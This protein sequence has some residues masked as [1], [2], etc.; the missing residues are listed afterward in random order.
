MSAGDRW[1]AGVDSGAGV[2]RFLAALAEVLEGL[3]AELLSIGDHDVG[4]RP[5]RWCGEV[6]A[7]VR[8]VELR[9]ALSRMIDDIEQEFG[10][11][12]DEMDRTQKQAAVRRLDELGA[13]LLRG[14]VED[15]A[16]TM[17][18]SKVT[19]YNYLNAINR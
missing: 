1:A 3:G 10:V 18:T 16:K 2:D 11:S 5:V 19:L 9:G 17:G 8:P 13:F 12:L 4:D 7:Y 14:A 15:V 6:V